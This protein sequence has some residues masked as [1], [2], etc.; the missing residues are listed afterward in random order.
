M[1]IRPSLSPMNELLM[2]LTFF[3]PDLVGEW[4]QRC[5]MNHNRERESI[6]SNFRLST[7]TS[8]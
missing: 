6:V 3:G 2:F 1:C 5:N 8:R 7:R 4:M